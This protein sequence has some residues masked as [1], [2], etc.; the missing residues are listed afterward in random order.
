MFAG[1]PRFVMRSCGLA[2]HREWVCFEHTGYARQKAVQWWQKRLPDRKVPKTIAEALAASNQLP[3]PARI[4]VRPQGR[5]TEITGYE[6][7]PCSA[8]SAAARP[9]AL[10]GSMPAGPSTI[11]AEIGACAISAPSP[12][13]TSAIGGSA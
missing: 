6:F 4:S 10:A 9:A 8:T 13:I 7:A 2:S 12:V 11:P 5:Y 1:S 3:A